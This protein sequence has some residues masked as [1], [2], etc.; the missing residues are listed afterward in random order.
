MIQHLKKVYFEIEYN[1]DEGNYYLS[2]IN[3]TKKAL[4]TV[5]FY[6]INNFQQ[7]NTVI[8]KEFKK[9]SLD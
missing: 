4:Q 5:N 1:I 7:L 3:F 2:D 9:I 8:S 6:E